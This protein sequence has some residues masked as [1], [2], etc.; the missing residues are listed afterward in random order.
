MIY[1]EAYKQARSSITE[2]FLRDEED[3]LK[4]VALLKSYVKE[5]ALLHF[6]VF[7]DMKLD[8]KVRSCFLITS[9]YYRL[10]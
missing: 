8:Q 2:Y 5:L 10:M 1:D 4:E 6:D 7:S 9:Q 3:L